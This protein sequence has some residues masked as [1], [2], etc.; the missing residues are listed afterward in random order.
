M[1]LMISSDKGKTS[2]IVELLEVNCVAKT[3]A[4]MLL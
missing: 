2:H 1:K 4:S 3:S